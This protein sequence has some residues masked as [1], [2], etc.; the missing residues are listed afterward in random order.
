[1]QSCLNQ[2]VKNIQFGTCTKVTDESCEVAPKRETLQTS[3]TSALTSF[4]EPSTRLE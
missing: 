1:V 4:N 3:H 2:N